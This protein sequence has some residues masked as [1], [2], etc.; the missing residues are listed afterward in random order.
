MESPPSRAAEP[1]VRTRNT[2]VRVLILASVAFAASAPGQSFLISV[3]V[4][5]IL[6]GTGLSRTVFS[7]LYA[8]GTVVSAVTMMMLGRIIDRRGLRVA[9][10]AVG[11]VLA[12]ACLAASNAGG[13]VLV[14]VALALL[15]TSGQGSFPLVGTLLVAG[16]FR[17]RRARAHATASLAL[18]V[19]SVVLPPLVALLIVHTDWRTAYRVIGVVI[20]I[21]VVPLG[22]LV[23]ERSAD[24]H[25]LDVAAET[26][27][28]AEYPAPVRETRWPG[29]VLPTAWTLRLLAVLAAPPLIGTAITFH[30]TSILAE[31]G[32][33][34]LQAG[35]VIGLA[36]AASALGVILAGLFVDR[37]RTT[38]SL[39]LMS[40]ALLMATLA[41]LTPTVPTAYVAFALV[42]IGTGSMNVIN[43][44]VW[45]RTFG[46]ARLGR[47]QGMAFSSTIT[48]AAVA[49]LVPALSLG[50]ADSY[51]PGLVGLAGLAG[52]ALVLSMWR[53]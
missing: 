23:P 26:E 31:R 36:G 10:L 33:G 19:A 52:L 25:A 48:A 28:G 35:T 16:S 38:V 18:M 7:V 9:W 32:I 39:T 14:F 5:E 21:A 47:I 29:V 46:T 50:L 2:Q 6:A 27:D 45:A 11:T 12:L 22:L 4:D 34:Y 51:Q 15:R 43:G 40:A 20:A 42:G 1:G 49:P 8:A 3:F 30:A 17:R 44:T 53:R 41:L 37:L 24:R 13:M